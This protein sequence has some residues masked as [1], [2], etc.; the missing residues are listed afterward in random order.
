MDVF[1]F[2]LNLKKK[3]WKT[4]FPRRLSFLCCENDYRLAVIG[5]HKTWI[6]SDDGL[7]YRCKKGRIDFEIL[8]KIFFSFGGIRQ[9]FFSLRRQD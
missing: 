1:F 2:F 6:F 7:W 3:I 4:L 5:T 8:G 9:D